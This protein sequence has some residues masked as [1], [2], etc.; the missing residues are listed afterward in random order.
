MDSILNLDGRMYFNYKKLNKTRGTYIYDDR[1]KMK[2]DP[3]CI[4]QL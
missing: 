1:R 4:L 2:Q 3:K